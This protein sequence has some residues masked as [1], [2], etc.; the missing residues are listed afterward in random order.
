MADVQY[1]VLVNIN[2]ATET[3]EVIASRM[4][5]IWFVPSETLP[6]SDDSA[7]LD[8]EHSTETT[9]SLKCILWMGKHGTLEMKS[10]EPQCLLSLAAGSTTLGLD[11]DF[12][13]GQ[14]AQPEPPIVDTVSASLEGTTFYAASGRQAFPSKASY[15]MDPTQGRY[16]KSLKLS[17]MSGVDAHWE[18]DRISGR[19]VAHIR[20]P[21]V[22]PPNKKIVP[23]FHTC[24]ISRTYSLR[25]RLKLKTHGNSTSV[26]LNVPVHVSMD[27]IDVLDKKALLGFEDEA[28]C[29]WDIDPVPTYSVHHEVEAAA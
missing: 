23:T 20:I 11:L 9:K 29:C 24:L 16:Q 7:S 13:R 27:R 28:E 3:S 22:L 2:G 25:L 19:Q 21:I 15:L 6:P 14:C 1:N 5:S 26:E 4:K 10:S 12:A 18:T 8:D 17:T